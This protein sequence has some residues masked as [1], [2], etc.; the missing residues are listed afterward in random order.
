MN[1]RKFLPLI[2]LLTLS[3]LAFYIVDKLLTKDKVLFLSGVELRSQNN[4]GVI[5]KHFLILD[6]TTC[7]ECKS[8][9]YIPIVNTKEIK[10]AF[11]KTYGN[12]KK[13]PPTNSSCIEYQCE[14]LTKV[15][16]P[17]KVEL[18]HG[19]VCIVIKPDI[20]DLFNFNLPL[21]PQILE[22]EEIMALVEAQAHSVGYTIIY[23]PEL[24][25]LIVPPFSNPCSIMQ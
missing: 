4:N 20:D 25:N 6:A 12:C 7:P 13:L 21:I 16:C 9:E 22:S 17:N 10:E 19:G 8:I 14:K 24:R 2:G 23:A 18:L 15:V 11:D 1:S 5:S 3:L